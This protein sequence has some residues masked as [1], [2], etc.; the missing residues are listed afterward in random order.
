MLKKNLGYPRLISGIVCSIVLFAFGFWLLMP[1]NKSV[2]CTG[3]PCGAPAPFPC[4]GW[5]THPGDC[6]QRSPW[7]GG[8]CGT[9]C[10]AGA[11][12]TFC[13]SQT[14]YGCQ[15]PAVQCNIRYTYICVAGTSYCKCEQQVAGYCYR[16]QCQ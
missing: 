2:A 13:L 9:S 10:A 1:Q 6:A 7:C 4:G 16:N 14:T 15:A 8:D 12:S 3:Y 11:P 5:D